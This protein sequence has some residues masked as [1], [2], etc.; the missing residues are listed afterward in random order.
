MGSTALRHTEAGQGK[1]GAAPL[2]LDRLA[3]LLSEQIAQAQAPSLFSP[4][5]GRGGIKPPDQ[6]HRLSA[7][8]LRGRAREA[9][10]GREQEFRDYVARATDLGRRSVGR[11]ALLGLRAYCYLSKAKDKDDDGEGGNEGAAEQALRDGR[12]AVAFAPQVKSGKAHP[13]AAAL[14]ARALAAHGSALE[15]LGDYPAAAVDLLDASSLLP[16]H[17][18][19]TD[20]RDRI[21]SKLSPAQRA[22]VEKGGSRGLREWIAEQKEL[23]LPEH[24]RRRPKY[25]YYYEWM[26]SRIA[27]RFPD[28][29]PAVTDKLLTTDADELDLLL[30]YP[31]AIEG[32]VREYLQVLA[33]KGAEY[34]ETYETPRLSWDEVRAL[35]LEQAAGGEGGENT[36]RALVGGGGGGGLTA[37]ERAGNPAQ[38][39]LRVDPDAERDEAEAAGARELLRQSLG[40]GGAGNKLLRGGGEATGGGGEGEGARRSGRQRAILGGGGVVGVVGDDEEEEEDLDGV[41]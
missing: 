10:L 18:E 20:A 22:A 15:H 36:R 17:A 29:P 6:R 34:L 19:H 23:A 16:D 38:A 1:D 27:E 40:P 7:A 4:R 25:Y 9:L 11:C 26:R 14:R 21:A 35:G 31:E 30:Q 37:G 33:E 2:D 24:Q 5:D 12:A 41:D 39:E 32:Q 13:L 8:E 3:D 28:L